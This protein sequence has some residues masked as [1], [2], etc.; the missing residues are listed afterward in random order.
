MKLHWFHLA[1]WQNLPKDF[2]ETYRSVWVD[3][4]SHLFN[5][6]QANHHYNDF[7]DELELAEGAGVAGPAL[8]VASGVGLLISG[9]FPLREDM[10]GVTYDPGGHLVG[11]VMF[12]LT[13]GVGLIVLSRRLR[14][15]ERWRGLASY[16][17]GAGLAVV[18]AVLIAT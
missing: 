1:P 12:F 16:T 5:P 7:L 8:L 9:I 14:H 17:L 18:A 4:P 10:A 2:N 11:G 3:V 6:V 15:D 13:S